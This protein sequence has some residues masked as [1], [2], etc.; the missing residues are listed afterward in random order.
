MLPPISPILPITLLLPGATGKVLPARQLLITVQFMNV[1]TPVH[2]ST[3]PNPAAKGRSTTWIL[4]ATIL[5]SS[6]AFIDG[7]VVNVA[8]PVLQ[9][10]LNASAAD[11]QWVIEAYSLFLASLI[12]VGGSLGDRYGRRRV[13]TLGVAIFSIASVICGLAPTVGVLIVARGVQ[14]IGGALLVPGSL[15]I[16]SSSFSGDTERGRAI[17][18]WSAFTTLTSAGGPVLGGWLVQSVSWRAIFFINVPI[19]AL[20]L[21]LLARHVPES[22][23]DSISGPL[24]WAG[25]VAVTLGLAALV[26]GFITWGSSGVTRSVVVSISIGVICLIAFVLVEARSTAPMLPLSLFR[27]RTFTGTNL[28]T[29]LLYGALGGTLFYLPFDLQQAQGY[30]ATA[31]G[32]AL[33]PLTIVLFALSRWAG[34]LVGRYGAKLPLTIGP[35]IAAVGFFLL[36]LPRGG[37]YWTDVFPGVLVL[38]LGMAVTVAPLTTAVMGAV[39]PRHSG[40]ASG[41]NNAVSRAAGLL[42]IAVLGIVVANYFSS[43]LD[44]RLNAIQLAPAAR[45]ALDA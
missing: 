26:Y 27:S 31:A 13:Y 1:G 28:L 34:G 29:F 39:D 42:A 40:V 6:L 30:S 25:A 9:R 43:G 36:S 18:T 32:A 4:A 24:D 8:L 35:I 21:F 22:K 14:G 16:I 15:A 41:V 45:H 44:H 38:G 10:D 19:A 20:V 2:V 7:S 5:G 17:G 12:L 11:V 3:A 33:V 37:N 23:D